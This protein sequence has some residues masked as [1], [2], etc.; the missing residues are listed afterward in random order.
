VEFAAELADMMS[1]DVLSYVSFLCR[2]NLSKMMS[3]YLLT[4]LGPT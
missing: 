3:F 2:S 4:L 1:E